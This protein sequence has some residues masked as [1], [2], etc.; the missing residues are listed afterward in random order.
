MEKIFETLSVRALNSSRYLHPLSYLGLRLF[1]D[2]FSKSRNLSLGYRFIKRK[3]LTRKNWRYYN[4]PGLKGISSESGIEYRTFTVG[5]PTTLLAEAAILKSLSTEPIFEPPACA[6]SYLWPISGKGGRNFAYYLEGYNKRNLAITDLMKTS[7]NDVV[8]I[9]DIEKFY[10]K[11]SKTFL[12]DRLTKR[13]QK[14]TDRTNNKNVL[15][16]VEYFLSTSDNGIPIGPDMGHLL[17]HVALEDV[18]S[19]LSKKY[20]GKYLRYVDDIVIV[21]DKNRIEQVAYDLTRSLEKIEL[22]LN[23]GKQ[24]TLTAE[25]WINNVPVIEHQNDKIS[26]GTLLSYLSI[27]LNRTPASYNILCKTFRDQGFALPF[28]RLRSMSQYKRYLIY[29]NA[30]FNRRGRGIRWWKKALTMS[31]IELLEMAKHIRDN[32][33]RELKSVEVD[34]DSLVGIKRRWH[35]QKLRFLTNRLLYLLSP[36]DYGY[37]VQLIPD[38]DELQEIRKILLA[39]DSEDITELLKLPGRVISTFCELWTETKSDEPRFYIE[40]IS[41]IESIS[42]ATLS[43]NQVITLPQ[44]IIEKAPSHLK[45]LLNCCS[46]NYKGGEEIEVLSYLDELRTLLYGYEKEELKEQLTTRFNYKEGIFLDG[47]RLG[48]SEFSD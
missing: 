35:I 32:M 41:E 33:I 16:Y 20:G 14:L 38:V 17:G 13:L 22:S 42:L 3:I 44:E 11:V 31:N 43:L 45:G 30:L 37:L 23:I 28:S 5:S 12:L 40:E 29:L 6:F 25:E 9:F 1:I 24:D 10:P 18:D 48:G 4:Y 8:Y 15:D 2:S 47:L 27:Y 21:S 7:P 36:K 46:A 26:F 39:F 19:E 34:I